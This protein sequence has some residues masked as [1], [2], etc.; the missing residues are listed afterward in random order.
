MPITWIND[1][2]GETRVHRSGWPATIAHV[3]QYLDTRIT[4]PDD[5]IIDVY[6]DATFYWREAEYLTSTRIPYTNKWLGVIHHTTSGF[7]NSL[8]LLLN[9]N[10]IESLDTCVGLIVLSEHLKTQLEPLVR[11]PIHVLTHPTADTNVQFTAD[12]FLRNSTKQ[13][14]H[15]GNWMRD[16]SEFYAVTTSPFMTKT[17][18]KSIRNDYSE[19]SRPNVT[20]LDYLADDAYDEILSKNVVYIHLTD[21][22]AINTIIECV[23]RNCP[24]IVPPLPAV[25]EVLG[26]DYPLYAADHD[27]CTIKCAQLHTIAQAHKHLCSLDKS[28]FAFDHF[29]QRLCSLLTEL[30]VSQPLD[31]CVICLEPLSQHPDGI[32]VLTCAHKIGKKCFEDWL[33][34]RAPYSNCPICRSGTL[35]PTSRKNETVAEL[36]APPPRRQYYGHGYYVSDFWQ[37]MNN[38]IPLNNRN[39]SAAQLLHNSS[40]TAAQPPHNRGRNP[41]Q[42]PRRRGLFGWF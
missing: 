1:D 5:L 20:Y 39:A 16:I 22:S 30:G 2:F 3:K 19:D 40:T 27:E 17:V 36:T 6:V 12:A 33:R 9:D 8:G 35:P 10:F 25:I 14:L 41:P 7:S 18:L 28:R 21:A 29:S 15:V 34:A 31:P 13:L 37:T 42:Q 11:V 23:M 32:T 24:I 4:I 38:G 26:V